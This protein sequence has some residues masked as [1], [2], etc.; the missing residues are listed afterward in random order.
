MSIWSPS[1]ARAIPLPGAP[2]VQQAYCY[3][4]N[5]A[6]STWAGS[7][8]VRQSLS[9][10]IADPSQ[11]L[12]VPSFHD[13]L[14]GSLAYNASLPVPLPNCPALCNTWKASGFHDCPNAKQHID[15]LRTI[16]HHPSMPPVLLPTLLCR[17]RP[18]PLQAPPQRL[19]SPPFQLTIMIPTHLV[20]PA[21]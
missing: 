15:N 4:S 3:G 21:T 1:V 2:S 17:P 9:S 14:R 13:S 8:C 20:S 5:P 11:R 7:A 18:L 12:R 10:C 6:T 19:A 16:G